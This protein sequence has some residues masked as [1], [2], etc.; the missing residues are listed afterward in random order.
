VVPVKPGA[1]TV[2]F[3]VAAGLS[4][5]A[6]AQLASGGPVQGQFAVD[7]APAP[8][9][10]YVDPATGRVLEGTAPKNP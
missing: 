8:P 3:R 1:H 9:T 5:R 2:H 4:G 10:T 6:H 7:I